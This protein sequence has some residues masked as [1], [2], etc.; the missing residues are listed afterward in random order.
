MKKKYIVIFITILVISIALTIK[1]IRN[2]NSK[3]NT[4]AI[5]N[6][7][8]FKNELLEN[9]MDKIK[10]A[11]EKDGFSLNGYTLVKYDNKTYFKMDVVDMENTNFLIHHE[12]ID[13]KGIYV[14]TEDINTEN[15]DK[16]S[17]LFSIAIRISDET[18]DKDEI[19]RIIEEIFSN[20]NNNNFNYE[21][22]YKND[23]IYGIEI[24]ENGEV[25]FY[26]E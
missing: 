6:S 1:E 11:L 5:T 8:I 13:I 7:K 2:I 20:L 9:F 4:V 25:I 14:N 21:L 19:M 24:L 12:G 26:V 18:I 3:D 10:T 16:I 17:S 15:I 23:L 22:K